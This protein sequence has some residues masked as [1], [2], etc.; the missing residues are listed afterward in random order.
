MPRK[1]KPDK[2]PVSPALKLL[3]I[4]ADTLE[5]LPPG[6]QGKRGPQKRLARR[7]GITT[8]CVSH[9]RREGVPYVWIL[10][11]THEM[12]AQGVALPASDVTAAT[13]EA[14]LYRQEMREMLKRELL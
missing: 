12:E 2:P 5:P 14:I 10:R 13:R 1:H 8:A 6:H 3:T 11:L 4:A 7:Y 9:W